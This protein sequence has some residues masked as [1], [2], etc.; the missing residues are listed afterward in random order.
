MWVSMV[1]AAVWRFKTFRTAKKEW[2]STARR[3]IFKCVCACVR[4][5][6]RKAWATLSRDEA[7]P[8]SFNQ[9]RKGIFLHTYENVFTTCPTDTGTRSFFSGLSNLYV[10]LTHSL[11]SWTV[12]PR[13]LL[14]RIIGC[15]SVLHTRLFAYYSIEWAQTF[16]QYKIRGGN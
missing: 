14:M 15:L 3:Y 5:C 9:R 11:H 10:K 1:C 4:L 2:I 12:G 8:S 16:F 13:F 6:L 7:F